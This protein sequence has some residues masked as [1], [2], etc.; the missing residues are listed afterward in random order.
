MFLAGTLP[1]EAEQV[2]AMRKV[3]PAMLVVNSRKAT[4]NRKKPNDQ[5]KLANSKINDNLCLGLPN[6]KNSV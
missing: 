2:I 6:K 5:S 3:L 4:Q 1:K